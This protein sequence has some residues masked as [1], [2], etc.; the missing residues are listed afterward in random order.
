[1]STKQRN[2]LPYTF[3]PHNN[4]DVGILQKVFLKVTVHLKKAKGNVALFFTNNK[5]TKINKLYMRIL[6]ENRKDELRVSTE[7]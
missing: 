4:N 6:K 7:L 5:L 1:M 3:S 2:S